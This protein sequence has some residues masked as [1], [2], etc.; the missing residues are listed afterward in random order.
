MA[1]FGASGGY[2][3]KESQRWNLERLVCGNEWIGWQTP[4]QLAGLL[5]AAS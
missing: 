1:A 3:T 4:E 2:V 5:A